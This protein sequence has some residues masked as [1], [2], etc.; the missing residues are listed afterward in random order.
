MKER[1]RTYRMK[2]VQLLEERDRLRTQYGR[3]SARAKILDQEINWTAK[4]YA[5]ARKVMLKITLEE[6]K[7]DWGKRLGWTDEDFK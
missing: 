5:A 7:A 3:N 4:E 2:L 6:L 1:L